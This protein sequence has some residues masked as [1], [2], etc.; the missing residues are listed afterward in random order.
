MT[1]DNKP[2]HRRRPSVFYCSTHRMDLYE[3]LAV[4]SIFVLVSIIVLYVFR[5]LL[6]DRKRKS[7]N[8]SI[9]AKSESFAL[10]PF[11]SYF[12]LRAKILFK[13]RDTA[14]NHTHNMGKSSK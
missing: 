4:A 7:I 3:E 5:K 9:S 13:G 14:Y 10:K 12:S 11:R 8:D 6:E 1:P 2:T